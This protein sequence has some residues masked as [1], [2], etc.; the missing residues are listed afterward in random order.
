M[1][2]IKFDF[3]RYHMMSQFA[4]LEEYRAHMEVQIQ[5]S[6]HSTR[7]QILAENQPP[8][9]AMTQEAM[10]EWLYLRDQD[11]DDCDLRFKIHFPRILR[12][13]MIISIYTLMESNLALIAAKMKTQKDLSLDM[14]DLQAKNLV[15]RFEKFWTRVAGLNWWKDPRWDL[16]KDIEELR[17]CIAHRNGVA[18]PNDGRIRQ[19]LQQHNSGIRLI[20]VDNHLVD[21]DDRGTLQIDERFCQE[22]LHEMRALLNEIFERAGCFG[23]DHVVVETD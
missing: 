12:F 6:H 10:Q 18:R 3:F 19:L 16:L 17:N 9:D 22:G 21:P 8:P 2:R 7:A 4:A 20:D 11:I 15:K 14:V 13:S 23:P 5:Q 1:T